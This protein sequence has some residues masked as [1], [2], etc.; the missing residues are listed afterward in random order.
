MIKELMRLKCADD[1]L[2]GYELEV[3]KASGCIKLNSAIKSAT[4][5]LILIVTLTGGISNSGYGGYDSTN[6]RQ[7]LLQSE[8]KAFPSSKFVN[9]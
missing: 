3:Q 8:Q 4:V 5:F 2:K 1:P 7:G 9:L 6:Q